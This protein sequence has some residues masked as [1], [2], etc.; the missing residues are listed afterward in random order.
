MT[1]NYTEEMERA[2]FEEVVFS[3]YYT[4]GI[5]RNPNPLQPKIAGAL[6]FVPTHNLSKSQLCERRPDGHYVRQE[7]SAMWHGWLLRAKI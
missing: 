5:Q 6:D 7:I 2:K 3:D 4:R 1:D